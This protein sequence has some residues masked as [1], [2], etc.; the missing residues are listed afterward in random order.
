MFLFCPSCL[1]SFS[2]SWFFLLHLLFLLHFETASHCVH[3]AGLEVKAIFDLSLLNDE[4]FFFFW[5]V[6]PLPANVLD[7]PLGSYFSA[8]SQKDK[9]HKGVLT[10]LRPAYLRHHVPV[11]ESVLQKNSE[12]TLNQHP[13]QE[14]ANLDVFSSHNGISSQP[15]SATT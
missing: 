11:L 15:L 2:S 9:F 1:Y 5:C 7:L 3:Q 6:L 12:S 8:S 10:G 4:I 13:L 14:W